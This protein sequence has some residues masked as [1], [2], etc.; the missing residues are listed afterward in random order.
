MLWIEDLDP[1]GE[2]LEAII[3]SLIYRVR[4]VLAQTE[5]A[6]S[7]LAELV[8]EKNPELALFLV[9]S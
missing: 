7:E 8:K 4:F 2:I 3:I 6:L 9:L 1:Q 5:H